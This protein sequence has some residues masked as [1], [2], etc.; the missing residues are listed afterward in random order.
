[1][2]QERQAFLFQKLIDNELSR[3]ELNEFLEHLAE[4]ANQEAYEPYLQNHFNR[5]IQDTR[6]EPDAPKKA[7]RARRRV[8]GNSKQPSLFLH[9]GQ[10]L[11]ARAAAILLLLAAGIAVWLFASRQKNDLPVLADL[12]AAAP[13][14]VAQMTPRGSRESFRLQDGSTALL[15][16]ASKIRYP[17]RFS[18]GS[19]Q[20]QLEGQA[21]FNVQRDAR[22]PFII[23]TRALTIEVLGTAFDVQAYAGESLLTVTVESGKVKVWNK[24]LTKEPVWLTRNQQLVID[25]TAASAVIRTVDAGKELAWRQGVLR[26]RQ[27]PVGD[28]ERVLERW[29]DVD[30]V[31]AAP[32]LL[33][34]TITGDH[35][36]ESLESV[37]E[38]LSFALN[39][40]YT[41]VGNTVTLQE[42]H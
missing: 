17:E 20:V 42:R 22:R 6:N 13:A 31:V 8:K 25:L 41:M 38:S 12:N 23:S 15:N 24:A 37:L 1:M 39:V 11:I 34:R 29:Y 16:A 3:E 26:F 40:Q 10:A 28:V 7:D 5:C 4:D 21:F 14:L 19:R 18:A 27:T 9:P 36:N 35:K 32:S 33:S 2:N 30:V